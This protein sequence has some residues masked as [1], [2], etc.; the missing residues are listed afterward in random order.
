VKPPVEGAGP[1]RQVRCHRW[2]EI[3]AGEI[4]AV[5]AE[6]KEV[7]AAGAVAASAEPLLALHDLHV[8]FDVNRSLNE[9]LTRRPRRYVRAVDGV[10]LQLGRQQ[11]LG[12]V[13][14]SGSGKTTLA[15]AVVGLEPTSG[16]EM[17]LLGAHLPS[18]LAR[19]SLDLLRHLQIVF[20]NPEEALNPYLTVGQTLRRPLKRLRDLSR[21]ETDDA[22]AE[23]LRDVRLPPSYAKRLPSQLSGGEKQRVALARAF[24]ANPDLLICDEPVSSLDVSVQASILNLIASLQEEHGSA[25]L[26]ISH[27]LAV[28]AYLA[29]VVAVIY[30]GQLMEVADAVAL[31]EPP[32]HPYTEALLS[33]IPLVDPEAT[34]RQVRLE[35]DVVSQI[36]VP[37][38]CP[39]HERCPRFLG[40]ICVNERPPWQVTDEGD[41]IFCHIPLAELQANQERV[42]VFPS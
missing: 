9:I 2:T 28:V 1:E 32:Y 10:D 7:E 42:F 33:A 18:G 16:G 13:G 36:D 24:A 15:R 14:E 8:H 26:F 31:L 41:R 25:V 11:T 5:F 40:D 29:D 12:L 38:G 17:R 22:V 23:L 19:R 35:G 6:N 21:D 4:S 30:A 20:Q 39:F 34:Q 27:D 37:S 3:A